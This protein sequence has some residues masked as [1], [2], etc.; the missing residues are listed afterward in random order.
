[1][2]DPV[3]TLVFEAE[4]EEDDV[5]RRPPRPP[6][7]PLLSGRLIVWGV[8]QGL[9]AL[10]LIASIYVIA[11]VRGMPENEARALAFFSLVTAIVA[12]IFANRSFG[13]SIASALRRPNAALKFVIAGVASMLALTMLWPAARHLF[14]FG[15]L[16]ADDLSLTVAAGF[17]VLVALEALKPLL[18]EDAVD[19]R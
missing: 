5:M 15:P 16:H 6:E 1:V 18:R 4:T 3:C 19:G 12:L 13:T 2:I 14:R 9:L 7:A 10:A 11:N 17:V 8:L